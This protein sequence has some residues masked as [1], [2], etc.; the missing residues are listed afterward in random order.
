M[1]YGVKSILSNINIIPK[2]HSGD[3]SEFS[4]HYLKT[5]LFNMEIGKYYFE[6][7][8]NRPKA[9]YGILI[10]FNKFKAENSIEKAT[11]FLK[12]CEKFL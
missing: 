11:K 1:F 2:K 4:K 9:N 7:E 3:M 12:E 6:F 8:K 5:K 10:T